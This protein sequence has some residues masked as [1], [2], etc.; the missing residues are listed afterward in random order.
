MEH[1]QQS[2]ENASRYEVS[3]HIRRRGMRAKRVDFTRPAMG[4]GRVESETLV[5]C[6][7]VAPEMSTPA[8]KSRGSRARA[9]RCIIAL[10]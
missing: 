1:R 10:F 3:F 6:G 8:A 4:F 2:E 7:S 5:Q 9:Y